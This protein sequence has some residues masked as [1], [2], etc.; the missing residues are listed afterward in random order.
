M[1]VSK[2]FKLKL[3]TDEHGEQ[4][5]REAF[6]EYG[7]FIKVISRYMQVAVESLLEEALRDETVS[8]VDDVEL[9][10]KSMERCVKRLFRRRYL[11]IIKKAVDNLGIGV[12]K[13][14]VELSVDRLISNIYWNTLLHGSKPKSL[15]GFS[16]AY[17]IRVSK[18]G[19]RRSLTLKADGNG[20]LW[21]RIVFLKRRGLST[22][23]VLGDSK[24][25]S[26]ILEAMRNH[27]V[28]DPSLII[29]KRNGFYLYLSLTR[30]APK[31]VDK[32]AG[33]KVMGVDLGVSGPAAA[34]MVVEC[35]GARW[36]EFKM[37]SH[38]LMKKGAVKALW[39]ERAMAEARKQSRLMKKGL[40]KGF[41]VVKLAKTGDPVS[42]QIIRDLCYHLVNQILDYAQ[43]NGVDLIA[44][45]DLRGLKDKLHKLKS[46]RREL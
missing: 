7:R 6:E 32:A 22:M 44:V 33:V 1:D 45:E 14:T 37:R 35:N 10:L 21:A 9:K 26:N 42:R 4:V 15:D 13:T 43:E 30:K 12:S 34:C 39:N 8:K 23:A 27:E 25:L 28:G 20:T 2:V 24:T 5:L 19:Y 36:G 40:K 17:P 46:K 11:P 38:L 41:R 3:H 16:N 31:K 18:K 29:R